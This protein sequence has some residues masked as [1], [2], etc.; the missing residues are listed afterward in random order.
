M[1]IPLTFHLRTVLG[2]DILTCAD[3][4]VA[5]TRQEV[6]E[7]YGQYHNGSVLEFAIIPP[8]LTSCDSTRFITT[9]CPTRKAMSAPST[10]RR[11]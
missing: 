4:V 11:R 8:S 1:Q 3:L 7:Q 6:R 9:C 10:P 2:A 5:S